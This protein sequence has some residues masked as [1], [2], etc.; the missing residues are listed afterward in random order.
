M[1]VLHHYQCNAPF[2]RHWEVVETPTPWPDYPSI[3]CARCEAT[4]WY[5]HT[6]L[7]SDE[8]TLKRTVYHFPHGR[9]VERKAP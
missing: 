2:C 8:E 6:N 3:L 5:S 1:T 4:S 7:S 9:A